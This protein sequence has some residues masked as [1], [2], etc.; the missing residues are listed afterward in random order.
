[1]ADAGVLVA[2]LLQQRGED[3]LAAKLLGEIGEM[4]GGGASGDGGGG[5]GSGSVSD[6]R[7]H[8]ARAL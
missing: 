1:V 6:M 8:L 7:G 3:V 5:G 4:S 2:R